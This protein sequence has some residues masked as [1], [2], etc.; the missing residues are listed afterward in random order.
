MRRAAALVAA[1]AAL[2]LVAAAGAGARADGA[3]LTHVTFIGDSVPEGIAGDS[4]AMKI[5]GA[6]IDLDMEAATCRRLEDPSCPP[7]P[8]TAIQ[9]IHSLGSKIGPVVVISVGYNDFVQDYAKEVEDTLQAL[10]AANV[11]KVFWLTLREAQHQA[12]T[13]NA[14]IE[15]AAQKHHEVTVVDWNMYSRSHP[16]WFQKDGIHLLAAGS[17]AMATLVH[18]RLLQAG[19]A[20]PPPRVVTRTLPRA[21]VGRTYSVTVRARAGLKPYRFAVLGHVPL[22]LHMRGNGTLTGTPRRADAHGVYTLVFRVSDA[23]GQV[24]TRKLL[25][26]VS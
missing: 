21:R 2:V 7:N 8:P 17:E 1:S 11:Q 10:E 23:S 12:I 24:G 20:V 13:Q 9:L 26:R 16:E 14:E 18:K 3:T 19:V 22:G 6:G 4:A 15:A 25:L 5:V